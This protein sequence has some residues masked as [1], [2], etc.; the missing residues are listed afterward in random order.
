MS[1][2]RC[3]SCARGMTER[4]LHLGPWLAITGP[5]GPDAFAYYCARSECAPARLDRLTEHEHAYVLLMDPP[6]LRE[7][8]GSWT[9]APGP[10]RVE[11]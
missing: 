10:E 2:Y 11:T 7:I 8:H 5:R 6:R 1:E 4:R 3:R 9:V